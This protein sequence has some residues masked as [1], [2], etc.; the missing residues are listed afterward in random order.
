M[1]HTPLGTETQLAWDHV[2]DLCADFPKAFTQHFCTW[3]DLDWQAAQEINRTELG[4]RG[5]SKAMT[6]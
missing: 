2:R 6:K 3:D 4:F 5:F 1:I